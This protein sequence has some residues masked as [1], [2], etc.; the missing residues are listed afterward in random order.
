MLFKWSFI[1]QLALSFNKTCQRLHDN[2]RHWSSKPEIHY[3]W[4]HL[5]RLTSL[6]CNLQMGAQLSK[7][8]WQKPTCKSYLAHLTEPTDTTG[9]TDTS[10][11]YRWLSFKLLEAWELAITIDLQ[12]FDDHPSCWSDSH[13]LIFH[14]IWTI[15][16]QSLSKWNGP[17][18][19]ESPPLIERSTVLAISGKIRIIQVY[20]V[21]MRWPLDEGRST[22]G[23]KGRWSKVEWTPL[24]I[25]RSSLA[26]N[27]AV[28]SLRVSDSHWS[29]RWRWPT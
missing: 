2:A 16:R 23:G 9:P 17:V 27:Q 22:I 15:H 4:R 7:R 25:G 10:N 20:E 11:G 1:R 12:S 19:D 28:R 26:L 18:E 13:D 21:R 14:C 24:S 3:H 5:V 8:C 29:W 6:M